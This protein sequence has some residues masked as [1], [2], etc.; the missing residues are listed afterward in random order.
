[1]K[2]LLDSREQLPLEFNHPFITSIEKIALPVGDYCCKYEQGYICPVIFERKSIGDLYGTLSQGYERFKREIEKA[3]L[4]DLTLILIIEGSLSKVLKGYEQSQ[5]VPESIV[6]QIFTLFVKYN[7][8]PVFA[9]N[10]EEASRYITEFYLAVGHNMNFAK[11]VKD[12]VDK[13]VGL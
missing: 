12:K 2:I 11:V 4:L 9:K 6:K 5:R 10:R 13:A 8:T 7:L 1:M 3:K